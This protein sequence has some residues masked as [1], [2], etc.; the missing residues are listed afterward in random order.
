MTLHRANYAPVEP[1]ELLGDLH[2]LIEQLGS[3]QGLV[4]LDSVS[5]SLRLQ[6][7]ECFRQLQTFLESYRKT[8]LLPEE[9]PVINSAF[10]HTSRNQVR[11]LIALDQSID[12]NP[13]LKEFASASRRVGQSQLKRLQP[14][15]DQ[16]LVQ[17]YLQAV[18][19]SKAHGWHTIV[20]GITLAVY[21]L[22]LRQGLLAY[23]HQTL[24]GF[25]RTAGRG[26]RLSER[27][28]LDLLAQLCA[29]LPAAVEQLLKSVSAEQSD[30]LAL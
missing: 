24:R 9:L 7:V 10:A 12:G 18:E 17:R 30:S 22:P 11:E 23:A 28:S 20:Y 15:R 8:I 26:L 27:Q 5:A 16:R 4:T 3:I 6:P 21:S 14:L 25:I 2:P 13:V 1:S 19:A 29:K